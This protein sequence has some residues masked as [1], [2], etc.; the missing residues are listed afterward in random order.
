MSCEEVRLQLPDYAL[1]TLPDL[2]MAEV[3]R[4]LRGCASCRSE[5]ATLDEGLALFATAAHQAEPPP[6]LRD[7]VMAVLTEEW[8]D[9]PQAPPLRRRLLA[10]WPA[11]AAAAVVVAALTLAVVVQVNARGLSEDAEHYRSFLQALGGTD[12]RVAELRSESI[13]LEGSAILYDSTRGRSWVMVLAKAPGFTEEVTVRLMAA[14]GRSIDF[15][16]PM[17]FGDDGDGWS[18]FV[19]ASDLSPFNRIVLIASGGR[20]VGEGTVQT[21]H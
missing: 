21:E 1:G 19:T 11:L 17:T 18:G 20:V 5:A 7:R 15:R 8:A 14:D 12:V 2:E 3:R 9:T 6:E 16:F 4:H 10:R 13:N